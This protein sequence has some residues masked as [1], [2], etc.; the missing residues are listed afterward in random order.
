M[1]DCWSLYL[2]EPLESSLAFFPWTMFEAMAG[3]VRR[4]LPALDEV[5]GRYKTCRGGGLATIVDG[6][7]F[8]WGMAVGL[9]RP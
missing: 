2:V 4:G 1:L 8:Q 9:V 7:G 6:L 5:I 3:V